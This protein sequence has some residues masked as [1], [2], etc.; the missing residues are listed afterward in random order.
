MKTRRGTIPATVTGTFFFLSLSIMPLPVFSQD[1]GPPTTQERMAL[2]E[3]VVSARKREERLQDVPI[4][5][6]AFDAQGLRDRNIRNA[7]DVANFTPNFQL[8]QNLGRRLDVPNIR[9]Q[10]GPLIGGTAPN[11]SFFVDGV[12]VSGSIGSTSVANLE[13]IEVIRGPQSA[14]FGRA[15]FAGAVNYITRRP[16][17]DY[18]G[19]VNALAGQDGQLEVGAWGSGPIIKDKLYFFVGANWE[20]W[21]GQ[22]NN[23]LQDYDTVAGYSPTGYPELGINEPYGL[24]FFGGFNWD[25]NPQQAG[26]PACL[27][28]DG[29]GPGC[30][31]TQ[32]DS[33]SIGGTDTK[34]AT[35]K[36]TWNALESLQFNVK[37]ERSE[38][39]DDHFV[40][41]F[42]AA[43]NQ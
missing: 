22:W 37:Y 25:S 27:T 20:K 29:N 39:D 12:F 23:G 36:L 35:I 10:F 18:E 16:T 3:M 38:A 15:T 9:G 7:Y 8:T 1:N 24:D 41:L 31:V 2:E 5:I 19:Q 11:A 4:S 21:D 28:G 26:D 17:D 13:R 43:C 14:Q 33:S 42:R 40:Y 34:I 6:S 32:G 30:A